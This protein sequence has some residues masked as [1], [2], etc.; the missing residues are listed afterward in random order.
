M[1]LLGMASAH[2]HGVNFLLVKVK[3][4]HGQARVEITADWAENPLIPSAEAAQKIM[5]GLLRLTDGQRG[6]TVGQATGFT[7][8]ETTE[9][10]PTSPVQPPREAAAGPHHFLTGVTVEPLKG[11]AFTLS[12]PKGNPHDVMLWT[13]PEAGLVSQKFYLIAGDTTERIAVPP[14]GE[15]WWPWLLASGGAGLAV[16]GRW[17]RGRSARKALQ[18]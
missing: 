16:V 3:P 7:F 15:H 17:L 13:V 4:S 5:A 1:G 18:E 12:I 2:G 10:D 6:V 11:A 14:A 8:T 9:V